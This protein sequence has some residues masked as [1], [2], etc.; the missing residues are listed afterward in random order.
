MHTARSLVRKAALTSA[1]DANCGR[2]RTRT[3]KKEIS[4][5]QVTRHSTCTRPDT[6]PPIPPCPQ[7][8]FVPSV[9]N[10]PAS[11]VA[12][13]TKRRRRLES[14]GATALGAAS[15]SL[16]GTRT[17]EHVLPAAT[18]GAVAL[19]RLHPEHPRRGPGE[20]RRW[21]HIHTCRT[22]DCP[23]R[24][25]LYSCCEPVFALFPLFTAWNSL[26]EMESRN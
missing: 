11:N 12:A 21:V 26:L 1:L 18:G 6:Q 2:P 24:L 10:C 22:F 5:R 13:C 8:L 4:T 14:L 20:E 25:A 7:S 9:D 23:G 16:A 17:P 3:L 15:T 19:Q